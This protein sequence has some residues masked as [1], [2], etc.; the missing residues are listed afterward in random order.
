MNQH[1]TVIASRLLGLGAVALMLGLAPAGFAKA[2]PKASA[3]SP[4]VA[5]SKSVPVAIVLTAAEKADLTFMREEEKV[6]RDAYLYFYGVYGQVI[7]SNIA[8]SEQNHM[9]ALGTLLVKYG[10]PDP[11]AGLG[12]GQFST[13]EFQALY[14]EVV[15]LGSASLVDALSAGVL[16]EE[17]DIADLNTALSETIVK[18]LTTVYKNLLNGSFKHLAA[19][20]AWLALQDVGE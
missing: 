19:F 4:R 3:K 5:L 8:K 18:D 20:N 13:P 10:L 15:A 2:A 7:F 16:V 17:T 12:V 14:D 9:N 11:V 6:A 1:S